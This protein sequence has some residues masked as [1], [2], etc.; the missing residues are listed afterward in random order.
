[1]GDVDA[2]ARATLALAGDRDRLRRSGE[3]AAELYAREFDWPV[4]AGRVAAA[5]GLG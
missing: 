3:A 4:V 1:V 2:F 5:L